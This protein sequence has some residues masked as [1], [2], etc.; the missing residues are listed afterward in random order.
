MSKFA[1]ILAAHVKSSTLESLRGVSSLR[2]RSYPALSGLCDVGG[3]LSVTPIAIPA[4][5]AGQR[6]VRVSAVH[7]NKV[8]GPCGRHG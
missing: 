5:L 7:L 8:G 3:D 4:V 6:V 1:D 2:Y